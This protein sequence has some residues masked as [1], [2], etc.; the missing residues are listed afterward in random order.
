MVCPSLSAINKYLLLRSTVFLK[1]P[2]EFVI[3]PVLN[4][5]STITARSVGPGLISATLNDSFNSGLLRI[6]LIVF[7][8]HLHIDTYSGG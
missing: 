2:K 4:Y 7:R 3:A 1:K 8:K 6:A 5:T